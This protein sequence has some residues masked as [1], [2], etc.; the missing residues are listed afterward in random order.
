LR[1][2]YNT[3]V[4]LFFFGFSFSQN[5]SPGTTDS[6]IFSPPHPLERPTVEVF[7][8]IP[9]G[10]ISSMPILFSF[11]GASRNANDYRDFWIN[12]ANENEFMVFAPEFSSSNYPGLGDNYL[13][14][15]VF[16]DGDN[17]EAGELNSPNHWTF[18]VIEP[19][20]EYIK[21]D[22]SGSQ[23]SYNAWGHS[24]GAQFLHRFAM[25]VPQSNLGIGI[26]SNAGWYTVPE[27]NINYPY[28][29]G[30]PFGSTNLNVFDFL[31][32]SFDGLNINYQEFF[33]KNLLIHLGTNDNDPDSSG[34]R[35]NSV[36][37]NQ[38]GLNRYDRGHYFFE[39]SQNE[40]QFLNLQFNWLQFD[41]E[42]ISHND[43]LMANDALQYLINPPL[44]IS[45]HQ[46]KTKLFPNPVKDFLH[47]NSTI[48]IR[49]IEV[50][51]S[52]GQLIFRYEPRKNY[53]DID[54]SLLL[55]GMYTIKIITENGIQNLLILKNS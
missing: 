3:I 51:N 44:N 37:D 19:L 16:E 8:H 5:L 46:I 53:L 20:F 17:P 41:A 14:G 32:N 18:S 39:T 26:C 31:Q 36:V 23:E 40:A 24:G 13:M 9:S 45:L 27:D 22:I 11:H 34:L 2:F 55:D 12:M 38:Q 7:Y 42:D 28:G 48:P 43:Q 4:F 52:V 25:F 29:I 54:M 50:F 49:I 47:L 10:D 6:F 15:N 21:L 35:H 33:Q 1:R 30:L